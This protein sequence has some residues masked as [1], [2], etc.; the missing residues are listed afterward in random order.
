MLRPFFLSL[1]LLTALAGTGRAAAPTI[2]IFVDNVPATLSSDRI[3][4]RPEVSAVRFEVSSGTERSRFKLE[5]LDDTWIPNPGEMSF[6]VRFL[7]S[8]GDQIS[9][10]IFP[11]RS[12]SPGWK[13]DWTD[14]PFTQRNEQ[15]SVPDGA[16]K[17]SIIISS[18]GPPTAIGIYAIS[19]LEIRSLPSDETEG[20]LFVRNSQKVLEGP[21]PLWNKSGTHPSMATAIGIDDPGSTPVLIIRDD[22]IAAHA[23]WETFRNSLPPVRPGEILELSWK[24]AYSIGTGAS[25][26]EVYRRIPAGNYRLV[27]ETLDLGGTPTGEVSEIFIHVPRTYWKS[28]WFWAVISG[29]IALISF[30]IG[31]RAIRRKINRDIRH[32]QLISDERLRI[33][34]DL[35]DDLGTRLSHIYLL[36]SHAEASVSNAEEKQ[37]FQQ[38]SQMSGEL[39][40]ALSATVW[41]LN[42]K[43]DDLESLVNFLCRV[44][45]ELCK[46]AD[47]RCRIDAMSIE[48][49]MPVSH[50][51]RHNFSLAVKETINNALKHSGATEISMR[52]RKEGSILKVS[53]SDN[54][55]GIGGKLSDAGNGLESI[56]QRMATLHGSCSYDELPEGG[57]KVTMEA[58]IS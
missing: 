30:V 49:T 45:G 42:S 34:R 29:C 35:H 14:S 6:T 46:L 18:S 40:S 38:I 9:Q 37:N 26:S 10:K 58:P 41:L 12:A 51:F 11:V 56:A 50:E 39:I 13:N 47:I 25:S 1:P 43:N 16:E 32:A 23:D 27:A 7:N 2:D 22:D 5:G 24:E 21:D 8:N 20:R 17:F 57:L 3:K 4:T 54:G 53:V 36:G 28:A 44:L 19:A 55:V 15:V 31:K 48:E 52:I 33:A